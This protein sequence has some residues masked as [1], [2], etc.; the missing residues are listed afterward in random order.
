MKNRIDARN[1]LGT[2][3]FNVKNTLE[4]KLGKKI[5]QDEK[6]TVCCSSLLAINPTQQDSLS[7]LSQEVVHME[8]TW[9]Q[10]CI[11]LHY[12]LLCF[13]NPLPGPNS[14]VKEVP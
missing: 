6:D 2:Y 3:C 1:S 13:I 5:S 10:C 11:A 9:R 8:C 14:R 7:V 4:E 12:V